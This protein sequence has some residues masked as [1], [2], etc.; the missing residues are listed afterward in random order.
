M[1]CYGPITVST[2]DPT[3]TPSVLSPQP[4]I[5][6][7]T[8]AIIGRP[9]VGK[10]T[11]FNRILGTKTA[12]VDDVP[13]VTRDRN[14]A[15][16]NYR[17]RPFRLVDTGGLEPSASEGMLALIK[18]QSEL[19][20]EEAEI[21]ILL[22]DGRTG[23]M[24]QDREVV[25][26]LRGTTKPL[27][28]VVNKIDTPKVEPLVAD[29]YQ[30]GIEQL[31]PVSAEHG[32]GISELLDAIYPLLPAPEE[33]TGPHGMPRIA[34]VGRPNVGKS[35][36]VNAVLGEERVVVSDVP[37]TTRMP[38][39][40]WLSMMAVGICSPTRPASGAGEGGS[41]NRRPQR[42]AFAPGHRTVRRRRP[43]A[44]CRRRRDGTGH[45]DRRR[46]NTAGARLRVVGQQ[47]G[48]ARGR[49]AGQA[50]I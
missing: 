14:Y 9:N 33:H 11:L 4:T 13:G 20:I 28:V 8:V 2:T 18:R 10:S 36:L 39:T 32:I 41:R 38:S 47:M 46:G 7:P 43:L 5:V 19:A 3:P 40:R 44:R 22:M 30:L 16:A 21:L 49:P 27:F 31:F 37:G 35:T 29:F 48:P 50:E 25:H 45:Q 24:P 17:N 26:L 6:A 1:L 23:L 12:I 15:D 42:R 34:V